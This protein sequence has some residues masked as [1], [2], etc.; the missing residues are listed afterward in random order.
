VSDFRQ[1]AKHHGGSLVEWQDW[2]IDGGGKPSIAAM[3]YGHRMLW[4]KRLL[5]EAAFLHVYF[6][7]DDPDAGVRALKKR[8]GDELLV[9]MKYVRSPWML[10]ALGYRPDATLPAAVVSLRDGAT[11]GKVEEVLGFCD[12][13]GLQYQNSHTNVIEDNGLFPDVAPI[14]ALKSEADPYDLLNRG[15]L[16]SASRRT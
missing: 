7:P 15:R 12:E 10:K 3:V 2:D 8:Y 1:A 4:V 6:D 14:V 13:I 16:R 11:P 5:P 9:E